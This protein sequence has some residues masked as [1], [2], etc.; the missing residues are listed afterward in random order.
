M[1]TWVHSE[2]METDGFTSFK[3]AV[4]ERTNLNSAWPKVHVGNIFTHNVF[5]TVTLH[6]CGQSRTMLETTKW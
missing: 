2:H 6:M 4:D 5:M 1:M 3:L